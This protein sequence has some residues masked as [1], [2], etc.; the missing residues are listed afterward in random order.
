[1]SGFL[2]KIFGLPKRFVLKLFNP[3]PRGKIRWFV[4]FIIV[5]FFVLVLIDYPLYYNQGADFLNNKISQIK[6]LNFIKIPK[7]GELFFH[8]GLDIQGG[9]HLVYQADLS[10]VE[11]ADQSRHKQGEQRIV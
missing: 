3:T 4:F 10:K 6:Y 9:T 1:M 7:A 8:L 11:G 2:K 5:L